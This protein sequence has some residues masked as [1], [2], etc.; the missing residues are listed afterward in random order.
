MLH[1]Q[2]P[3]L[4]WLHLIWF[5][6]LSWLIHP[7]YNELTPIQ[8]GKLVTISFFISSLHSMQF[9]HIGC[10]I[11]WYWFFVKSGHFTFLL[12]NGSSNCKIS[13]T[14]RG[15]CQYYSAAGFPFSSVCSE[16]YVIQYKKILNAKTFF[17]IFHFFK[18]VY[19]A[20]CT[21]LSMENLWS[22]LWRCS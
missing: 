20:F 22:W 16:F 13:F 15:I 14:F 11:A 4:H 6:F 21:S 9:L 1:W 18:Q 8:N 5:S 17:I 2:I 7:F 12:Q 19:R 10:I 3:V